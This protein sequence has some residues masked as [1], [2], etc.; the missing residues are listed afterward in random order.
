[1]KTRH[2]DD[3][4]FMGDKVWWGNITLHQKHPE[5][6]VHD[7]R[8]VNVSNDK[9]FDCNKRKP[10]TFLHLT[11]RGHEL[12]CSSVQFKLS[13]DYYNFLFPRSQVSRFR[14]RREE[15]EKDG[16]RRGRQEKHRFTHTKQTYTATRNTQQSHALGSIELCIISLAVGDPSWLGGGPAERV[17]LS[18]TDLK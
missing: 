2:A 9:C 6:H 15:R 16:R 13:W 11:H 8:N 10:K 12:I 18:E 1:M 3:K 5:S 17:R 4:S 7:Q 14:A